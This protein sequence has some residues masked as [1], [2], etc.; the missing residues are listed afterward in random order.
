MRKNKRT[1]YRTNILASSRSPVTSEH[2]LSLYLF[3]ENEKVKKT[4]QSIIP[5][6]KYNTLTN[7]ND[8][9]IS[10]E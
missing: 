2:V 1:L 10:N 9:K 6:H 3:S 5:R 8:N 4:Q 7:A